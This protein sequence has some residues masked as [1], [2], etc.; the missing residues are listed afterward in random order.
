MAAA[1]VLLAGCG[2]GGAP[3]VPAPSASPTPL[4]TPAAS[5]PEGWSLLAGS[6]T[7]PPR[8]RHDD[9]VFLDAARGW[10]VNVRGEVYGTRD[11][12]QAWEKLAALEQPTFPR[13][14]G[15]AD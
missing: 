10:L 3:P 7:S 14:V 11:G 4:P 2:S 13:C 6:P 1:L 8:A 12:G 15:F 9:L 5:G